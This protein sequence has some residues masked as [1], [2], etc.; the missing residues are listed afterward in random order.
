MCDYSLHHVR[1]RSAKVNDK[2]VTTKLARSS[3]RGF[4]AVGEYGAKLVINDAPPKVAVCLLPGTELAF[5]DYVQYDRAFILFGK[6]RINHKL[7]LFRQ[8]DTNDPHVQHDVLEFPDGRVLKV[9]R[10]VAGQTARV[11]QL[12]VATQHLEPVETGCVAPPSD[13]RVALNRVSFR[14]GMASILMPNQGTAM[15]WQTCRSTA[16]RLS[17]ALEQSFRRLKAHRQN[18]ILRAALPAG[19]DAVKNAARFEK[20]VVAVTPPKTPAAQKP[21]KKIEVKAVA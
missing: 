11:L 8:I 2:L 5:D 15:L 21:E 13:S 17:I 20:G 1:S 4:A 10:L 19:G 14:P 9:A 7:A 18:T 16:V 6:A 12:P 3:I